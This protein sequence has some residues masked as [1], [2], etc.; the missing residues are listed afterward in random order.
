M[1]YGENLNEAAGV[2]P[3]A[4]VVEQNRQVLEVL[5]GLSLAGEVSSRVETEVN[6][7]L[8]TTYEG[9]SGRKF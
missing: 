1:A 2:M 6:G 9:E 5:G 7:G 3:G 8:G 4:E